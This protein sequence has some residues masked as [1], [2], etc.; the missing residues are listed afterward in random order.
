[1]YTYNDPELAL[2]EF[3][4]DFYDLALI[5]IDMP[6]MSG[7]DLYD[8]IKEIDNKVKVC[9]ITAYEVNYQALRRIFEEELEYFIRK[10]TEISNLIGRIIAEMNLI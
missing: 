7:F 3:K 4:P 5:D 9:F 1:M 8:K 10:P 6:T 2:L